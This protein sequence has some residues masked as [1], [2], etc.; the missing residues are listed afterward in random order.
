M[1]V[2][3]APFSLTAFVVNGPTLRFSVVAAYT[4]CSVKLLSP[5]ERALRARFLAPN[6]TYA[7]TERGFHLRVQKQT[8]D[9]ITHREE[10]RSG[11]RNPG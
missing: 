6:C 11:V 1:R 8:E 4:T 10:G 2:M 5:V 7:A 9:G 3:P